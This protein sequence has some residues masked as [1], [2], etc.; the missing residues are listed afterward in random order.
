MKALEREVI[1]LDDEGRATDGQ[2]L[3]WPQRQQVIGFPAGFDKAMQIGPGNVEAPGREC[4]VPVAFFNSR[5]GQS[6]FIIM[7][8]VFE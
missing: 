3:V 7:Q 8:L 5:L 6:D 4:L 2:G 1:E